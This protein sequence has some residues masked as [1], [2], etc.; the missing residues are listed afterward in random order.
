MFLYMT[1]KNIISLCNN[2]RDH[3]FLV[4]FMGVSEWTLTCMP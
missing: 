1:L 4:N 2:S 3:P